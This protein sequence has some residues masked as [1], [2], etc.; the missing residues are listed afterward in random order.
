[1][2]DNSEIVPLE[3]IP[4]STDTRFTKAS[5]S[6]A[7]EDEIM[8][9]L[10]NIGSTTAKHGG[11]R[12]L[13]DH[14]Y[15]TYCLLKTW[16]AP[17]FVQLAGL[18]HSIYST[19]VYKKSLVDHRKRIDVQ[20]LIGMRAEYLVYLFSIT[21]RRDLFSVAQRV[22][23]LQQGSFRIK[24]T[25]HSDERFGSVEI[26]AEDLV[27]LLVIHIAN[28]IEQDTSNGREP[29]N[30]LHLVSSLLL[31]IRSK[32][33]VTL[34]LPTT[35]PLDLPNATEFRHTYLAA[36]S[37]LVSNPAH[38]L[39]LFK[40]CSSLCDWIF[41]PQLLAALAEKLLSGTVPE[42]HQTARIN[43]LIQQWKVAWDT[44][45]PFKEW[46]HLADTICS[47]CSLEIFAQNTASSIINL[48]H[49]LQR[50]Y[51]AGGSLIGPT[52]PSLDRFWAYLE[53]LSPRGGRQHAGW[54][55][56]LSS[57]IFYPQHRFP[58]AT[59]LGKSFQRIR[60]E[61]IQVEE[62]GYHPE[63]EGIPR[64][65]SW[66]VYML[67]EQGRKNE[68]NCARVPTIE[69]VLERHDCVRKSGG[70]IYLSRLAPGTEIAPHNGPVNYRVRLH[71][72]LSIP[73]GDCGMRVGPIATKWV[74]GQCLVFSD[75]W[76]HEVWNRTSQSRIV[77]LVDM[78]HPDLSEAE[79]RAL[80][81]IQT[82]ATRQAASIAKYWDR[83]HR[84]AENKRAQAAPS[85][86][87]KARADFI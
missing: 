70:L 7:I 56:G 75:F 68:R 55:P 2:P 23:S 3:N 77:L 8:L 33:S 79:C 20:P 53:N 27:C 31:I 43:V 32:S 11:G 9:F 14:L 47:H 26:C 24:T 61:L 28:Q 52:A 5:M 35:A 17:D 82:H 21:A 16:S 10:V 86:K 80:E 39:T 64:T 65:G 42:E 54:Y 85:L 69:N 36:C 51:F 67:Y 87:H 41:E 81:A 29:G 84:A 62:L 50:A 40:H 45:L 25:H 48:S 72:A 58:V 60:D 83:N 12:S 73:E 34:P 74:E 6:P 13:F 78:W 46:C 59:D 18:F 44:R 38:A 71:F 4:A 19:E 63:S 15:G 22:V 37:I 76:E 66:D 1:M 30:W 57:D 49:T